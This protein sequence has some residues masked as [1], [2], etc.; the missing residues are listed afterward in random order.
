MTASR[1]LALPRSWIQPPQSPEEAPSSPSQT[2]R[3]R[4]V[5]SATSES[6]AHALTCGTTHRYLLFRSNDSVTNVS[7]LRSI[8]EKVRDLSRVPKRREVEKVYSFWLSSTLSVVKRSRAK[9]HHVSIPTLKTPKRRI[10]SISILKRRGR[11][12]RSNATR[13]CCRSPQPPRT[14]R[15]ASPRRP[16]LKERVV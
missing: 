2:R 16:A 1:P 14:P 7:S 6:Q 3:V 13:R 4:A 5:P 12:R 8:L 9:V 10:L 11:S 15:R